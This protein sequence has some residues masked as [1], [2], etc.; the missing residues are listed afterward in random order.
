MLI[1]SLANTN[2]FDKGVLSFC[3]CLSISGVERHSSLESIDLLTSKMFFKIATRV[4]VACFILQLFTSQVQGCHTFPEPVHPDSP[5]S[6]FRDPN[7][8]YDVVTMLSPSPNLDEGFDCKEIPFIGAW[9]CRTT[10]YSGSKGRSIMW[11]FY[12][13]EIPIIDPNSQISSI[14]HD[15]VKNITKAYQEFWD[16]LDRGH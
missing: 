12:I 3:H 14:R 7:G 4:I 13:P 9:K 2:S 8:Y 11:M 6:K 1:Q 15:F 16:M 5:R 10:H